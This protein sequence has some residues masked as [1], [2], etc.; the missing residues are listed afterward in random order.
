MFFQLTLLLAACLI[1]QDGQDPGWTRFA[2][3]E[4]G[5]EV[6]MPA[7]P[8]LVEHK[9]RP[10]PD[11][12]ITVHLAT[13]QTHDGK[14]MF[15]IAYHDLDYDAVDDD[16]IRDVLDG[17]VKGSLLNALGKLSKH[18]PIK[19]GAHPGRHF[20]YSGNRFER[21]IE[22]VSRI[23]L[24]GRRVYQITVLRSPELDLA[25][26]SSK[27]FD[28]FTLVAAAAPERVDPF[29]S[30]ED[31]APAKPAQGKSGGGKR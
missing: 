14:A 20:E 1:P 26:D 27:F 12:A 31:T 29:S 16:K 24:V 6:S 23:Y 28:S 25:A 13:A 17:G 15:M 7:E 3:K 4:G 19:L 11:R 5:F 22:A 10:L 9:V 8:K 30:D 2:P 18:E 21:K